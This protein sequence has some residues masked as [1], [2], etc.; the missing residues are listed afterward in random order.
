MAFDVNNI[1]ITGNAARECE[2]RYTQTGQCVAS[3]TL[4]VSKPGKKQPD[5]TWKDSP[6]DWVPVVVWGKLAEQCGN[7]IGKGQRCFVDGRLQIRD[8]ETN[9]GQK[10]RIAE[11]VASTVELIER[12]PASSSGAISADPSNPN[13]F[14]S[15]VMPDEEIPF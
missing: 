12:R 9:D 15:D 10:R 14:G 4:A 13:S 2:V 6:P 1:K 11:V 8:Y 5:G 7:T 3:F